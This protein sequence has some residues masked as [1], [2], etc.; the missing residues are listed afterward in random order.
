MSKAS[1]GNRHTAQITSWIWTYGILGLS[2][3][4]TQSFSIMEEQEKTFQHSG[5]PQEVI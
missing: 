1:S 4:F 5:T 2:Q 3:A